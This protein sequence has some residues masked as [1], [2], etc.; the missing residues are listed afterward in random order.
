MRFAVHRLL[1]LLVLAPFLA[2]GLAA[3]PAAA[4]STPSVVSGG[5]PAVGAIPGLPLFSP[6]GSNN[7]SCRPTPAK[8]YPVVLV[9]GTSAEAFGSWQ[10]LS[11]RLAKSGYCVFAL[12]YGVR[13]T[14]AIE[15][16][17]AELGVF[18]DHVLAAT[19]APKVSLVGHSQGGMMPRYYLRFLGGAA[20]V[21]E[22]IGAS[23]R[24]DRRSWPISTRVVRWRPESTTRTWSPGTTSRAALPQQVSLRAID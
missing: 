20:K 4:D 13:G 10:T 19:G 22:L 21:E 6:P 16:S 15:R 1:A 17:A 9:H 18:I 2:L 24:P 5:R 8:P 14:I 3:A 11:P 12:D 23:R 7:F